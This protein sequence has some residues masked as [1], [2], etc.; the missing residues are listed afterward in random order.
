MNGRSLILS[1]FGGALAV[2]GAS[3]LV[4]QPR[5]TPPVEATVV[6][7]ISDFAESHPDWAVRREG[8]QDAATV[9]FNHARHM[10]PDTVGLQD[11]LTDSEAHVGAVEHLSDGRLSMTCASCH[12]RDAAGRYM[13]PIS[14]DRHCVSCHEGN[15]E[16][17]GPRRAVHG[18]ISELIEQVNHQLLGERLKDALANPAAESD[19]PAEPETDMDSLIAPERHRMFDQVLA[20]CGKCHFKAAVTRPRRPK[21]EPF[22]IASPGIPDR[23]LNRSV[24]SHESHRAVTCLECHEQAITGEK[25]SDIMLP[26]IDSCRQCHTPAEGVRSDCVMCH[27]YHPP[28]EPQ[29][30]GTL[31]IEEY[32]ATGREK[33]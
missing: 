14:F 31:T 12:E 8:R 23:W 11:D 1:L 24:F 27:L 7:M 16:P 6:N 28:L 20:G 3:V 9:A 22:D 33:K 2:V 15:L 13:Q 21:G 19:S 5:T 26:S 30:P 10:N 4:A 18:D 32:A 29:S 25:T 17:I